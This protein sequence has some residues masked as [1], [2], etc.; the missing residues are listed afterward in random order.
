M[1]EDQFSAAFYRQVWNEF[2]EARR[3]FWHVPNELARVPGE[4][5]KAH[6]IRVTQAKAIGTVPG[7]T[8]W[9]ILWKGRFST[10]ELKVGDNVT[11]DA[12]ERFQAAIKAQGA[13]NYVAY[14][15]DEAM[16]AMREIIARDWP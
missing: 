1:T 10:I 13:T 12:Q 5:A 11:S 4:S 16:T 2:P 7:V 6:M 14:T 15:L 3:C 9:H 8:D